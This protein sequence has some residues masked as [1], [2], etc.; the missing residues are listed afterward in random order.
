MLVV[1]TGSNVGSSDTFTAVLK[2]ARF[3][4]GPLLPWIV[5][6][7]LIVLECLSRE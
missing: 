4:Y 3:T 6:N 7:D 1:P 5:Q 2:G